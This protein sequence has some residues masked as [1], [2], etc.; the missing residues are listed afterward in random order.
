MTLLL[1]RQVAGPATH[2][3]LVGVG[4]F[5]HAAGGARQELEDVPNLPSAADSVKLMCDWLLNNRD[6]LAAP[7][8]TL[9]VLISDPEG[10]AARYPWPAERAVDR[11]SRANVEEAGQR[12]LGRFTAGSNHTAIF[13]GCG[14]GASLTAEP[15]LFLDDLNKNLV[16]PW[17]HIHAAN[18]ARAL[19]V[20]QNVGTAYIF[21]DACGQKVQEFELTP[22]DHRQPAVFYNRA[23]FGAV[24]ANKVM[25]MAGAPE[26]QLAYDAPLPAGLFDPALAGVPIGRFTQTLAMALNGSS[27]RSSHGQW[28]VNSTGLRD[29][30]KKLKQFYFPKLNDYPFEPTPIYGFNEVRPFSY[31]DRPIVP[32]VATA[33]P[34][35]KIGDYMLAF[36]DAPPPPRPTGGGTPSCGIRKAWILEAPPRNTSMYAVAFNAADFFSSYP[37]TPNQPQF[38][39]QV[40]IG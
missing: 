18:L 29:D 19:R 26:G 12:W 36:S 4:D 22:L 10:G 17:P 16:N 30:L 27:V 9:E 23:A 28:V 24:G 13:Y 11:A 2:A 3:F 20:H 14:H 32:I 5:P 37:F 8:A 25:L 15:V 35:E 39:L 40:D 31:P 21:I 7:L 1:D 34:A 38:D 33:N 6:K